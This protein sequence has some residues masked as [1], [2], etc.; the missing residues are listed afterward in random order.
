MPTRPTVT[1]VRPQGRAGPGRAATGGRRGHMTTASTDGRTKRRK[2]AGEKTS[3]RLNEMDVG[4][5]VTADVTAAAAV[6]RR[7]R[8]PATR[9]LVWPLDFELL[10]D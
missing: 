8:L 4:E 1:S 6:S 2:M 9:A 3:G 7:R 10:I 5:P